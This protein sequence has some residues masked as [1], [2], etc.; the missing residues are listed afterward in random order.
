MGISSHVNLLSGGDFMLGVRV[1]ISR[2]VDRSQPGW[3]ECRLVDA[4]GHEH[5]FVEKVPVVTRDSLD[6]T[7]SYPQSGIIAC[8]VLGRSK[9]SD[10]RLLVHID[11]QTPWGVE[12]TAGKSQ[13]DAFAG[14]LLE[15]DS[16][17]GAR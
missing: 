8:I 4:S 12:S 17:E 5:V 2:Y 11:T 3:V 14:Q 15:F 9:R 6:A 10:G 7:S 13:F 16:K 1:E